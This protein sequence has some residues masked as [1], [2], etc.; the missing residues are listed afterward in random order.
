MRGATVDAGRRFAQKRAGSAGYEQFVDELA[1]HELR[2]FEGPIH[3]S[4]WYAVATYGSML[5]KAARCLA[6]GGEEQFLSDGGKFVVDDGVNTL[7]RAFFLVASPRFVLRG[8]ALLWRSF[9][10]GNKL[11][12]RDSSKHH[13][14]GQIVGSSYCDWSL[15]VS[16]RGGMVSSLEHAGAKNV[17]VVEH[18]CLSRGGDTCD[19]QFGWS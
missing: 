1:P 17:T 10:K 11:K 15:C 2:L 19:F 9:F 8:S 6:P 7:Y 16:I 4:Q 14:H 5:D 3:K 12:I 18:H 13:V